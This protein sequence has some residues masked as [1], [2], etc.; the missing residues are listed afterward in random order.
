MYFTDLKPSEET[1]R[2]YV[3][4]GTEEHGWRRGCRVTIVA[5]CVAIAEQGQNELK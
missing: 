2:V 5:C 4:L 3:V 1:V